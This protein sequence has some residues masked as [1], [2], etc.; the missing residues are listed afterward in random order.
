MGKLL[1]LEMLSSMNFPFLLP[2]SPAIHVSLQLSLLMSLFLSLLFPLSY[3]QQHNLPHN[4]SSKKFKS[5]ELTFFINKQQL[6]L[7]KNTVLHCPNIFSLF[8]QILMECK[9]DL[10]SG[11]FKRNA[12]AATR[13]LPQL[14]RLFN[15]N[16]GETL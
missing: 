7:R 5:N 14:K 10:K 11:T 1:Y 16:I 15:M 13:N 4:S 9:L 2:E 12:F 3:Q 6:F 8:Q